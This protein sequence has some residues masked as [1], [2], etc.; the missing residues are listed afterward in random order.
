MPDEFLHRFRMGKWSPFYIRNL[1]M[2]CLLVFGGGHRSDVI[3]NMTM[4]EWNDRRVEI[5]PNGTQVSL[6]CYH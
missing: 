3:R 6:A 4:E 2:S 1:L 5:A